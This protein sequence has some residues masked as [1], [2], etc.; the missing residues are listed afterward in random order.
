MTSEVLS[1]RR[2]EAG[3]ISVAV[4]EL[5]DTVFT[6]MEDSST[7]IS[8]DDAAL[9]TPPIPSIRPIISSFFIILILV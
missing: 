6:V 4:K 9:A 3:V 7:P 5:T 1:L 2:I 8:A